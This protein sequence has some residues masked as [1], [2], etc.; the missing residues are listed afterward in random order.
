MAQHGTR[1]VFDT[2]VVVSGLLFDN[3]SPAQALVVPKSRFTFL[4]SNITLAELRN[5]LLRPKF[6]KYLTEAL[7]VEFLTRYELDVERVI[8]QSVYNICRD[9][10]DNKFLELAIDGKA[11]VI[12]TGDDDLLVLDPFSQTRILTPSQFLEMRDVLSNL[13]RP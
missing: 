12:V 3:S 5:V 11:D 13:K 2:N 9:P 4:A 1:V 6:D 8:I 10:K 7:R